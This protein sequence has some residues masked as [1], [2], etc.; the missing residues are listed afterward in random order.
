M[1]FIKV[2]SKTFIKIYKFWSKILDK[3]LITQYLNDF[4]DFIFHKKKK[5]WKWRINRELIKYLY[6]F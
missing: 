6:N 2:L 4:Q 3:N 1:K 5:T